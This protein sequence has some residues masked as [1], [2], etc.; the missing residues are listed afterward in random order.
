MRYLLALTLFIVGLLPATGSADEW[1][2]FPDITRTVA[3]G[4]QQV[5]LVIRGELRFSDG[6]VKGM[7]ASARASTRLD[8]LQQKIP[9]LLKKVAEQKSSC[10]TRWSFPSLQPGT[11]EGGK[12]KV[13][14]QVK[15]EQWVCTDGLVKIKTFLASQSADFILAVFPKLT[16]GELSLDAE[17]E[18]FQPHGAAGRLGLGDELRDILQNELKKALGSEKLQFPPEIAA[19]KPRFTAAEIRDVGG[20]K[21]ELFLEAQADITP[22]DM[23]NILQLILSAKK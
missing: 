8:E 3:V 13:G 4:G 20:G 19:I 6:P 10:T 16:A 18:K 9:E 12:L 11:I 15:V 1:T 22:A 14:G 2:P 21:G 23:T 7:L 5:T 17:L